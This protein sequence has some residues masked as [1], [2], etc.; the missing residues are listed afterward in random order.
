MALFQKMV[1]SVLHAPLPWI[2]NMPL[3]ETLQALE[4]DMYA[5]DYRVTGQLNNLLG[6]VLHLLFIVSTR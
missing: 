6:N 5:L 2:N 1:Q 4:H 3:G